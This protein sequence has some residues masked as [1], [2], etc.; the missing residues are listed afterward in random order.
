MIQSIYSDFM[1]I[2]FTQRP[3]LGQRLRYVDNLMMRDGLADHGII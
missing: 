2:V 3:M 1:G